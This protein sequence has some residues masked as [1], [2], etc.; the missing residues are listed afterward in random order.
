[1]TSPSY[2]ET[3]VPAMPAAGPVGRA[4]AQLQ[5]RA[6]LSEFLRARR[7]RIRPEDVGLPPG[8][9]RRTPGLRREEVAA[10]AN[11]GVTWY[12]WL[13]QGRKIH[14]STQVLV[15]VARVL[16]LDDAE[17]EHLFRLAEVREMPPLPESDC[18][19]D[20][21][22]EI[23]EALNPLPALLINARYDILAENATYTELF[24]SWRDPNEARNILWY[25]FVNPA[26]REHYLNMDEQ[27]PTLVATLRAS[28]AR[29]LGEP[30]W[31]EFIR[32]LSAASPEFAE[33]WGR[34]DVARPGV[35]FKTFVHDEVGRLTIRSTS[36]AVANL[37]DSRIV[38]YTAADEETRIKLARLAAL[39]AQ[40]RS[41]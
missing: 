23:L 16:R 40:A 33:M 35:T 21:V 30:V 31:I 27:L 9:R 6:E 29:H 25:C 3:P 32:A 20:S 26:A 5:R 12:T 2:V 34:H 8:V 41:A 4:R 36:L 17:R 22:R 39:V 11:V 18:V 1:V 7:S 24:R 14:V 37:P 19:P 13:E 28:F 15:S 10:L 38:V